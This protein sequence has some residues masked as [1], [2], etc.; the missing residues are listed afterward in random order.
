MKIR[1]GIN[2]FGRI[3]RT[4]LRALV[5]SGRR[6]FEVVAVNDLHPSDTLGHL[7]EYDS[8]HGRHRPGVQITENTIDVGLGPIRVTAQPD[9]A[10]LPWQDVDIALECSGA[11]TTPE[12]ALR[13]LQNGTRRVLLSAPAKGDIKTVVFGV[14]DEIITAEDL[15]ISNA[16]CTTNCLV[17]VAQVLHGTFGIERGMM[18]T[19]HCY[20]GNQP[21]QDAP[22]VDPNRG[23]AA[24]LSM[25]P[26]TTGAGESLGLVLP[27]LA[28]RITA[29]AIRVPTP[30]VSC[31]DLSVELRRDVSVGTV[32]AAFDAAA[33]GALS[34]ILATTPDRLVSSDLKKD[35]N[36]AI[37]ALDQT[38]VQSGSWV[39]VLAWYDNEW[40]FSNR[41]LDTAGRMGRFL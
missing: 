18:T 22:H 31:C 23:R 5:E 3:G 34:G 11:F 19:V 1:L 36:S 9:P 41:L 27:E 13:H 7:F 25:I 10:L 6:E 12:A 30:N 33:T 40:G 17:P 32:N 14:N 21:I 4:V 24:G 15:L 38:R 39:R 29:Q 2:G 37:I 26:T 8:L 20:T 28:G 16:S 35:P